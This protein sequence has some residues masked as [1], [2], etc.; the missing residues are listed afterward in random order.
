[1]ISLFY[2]LFSRGTVYASA[3]NIRGRVSQGRKDSGNVWWKE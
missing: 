3:Q 1:M 2:K